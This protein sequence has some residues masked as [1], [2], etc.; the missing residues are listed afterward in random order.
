MNQS[1]D[2]K[3]SMDEMITIY[4]N[5]IHPISITAPHAVLVSKIF[6]SVMQDFRYQS[7]SKNFQFHFNN[8]RLQDLVSNLLKLDIDGFNPYLY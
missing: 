2:S 4:S 5:R 6:K 3:L 7:R 1:C 8:E